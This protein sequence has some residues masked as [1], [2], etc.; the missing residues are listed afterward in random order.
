VGD[1]F[2]SRKKK[3]T[4]RQMRSTSSDAGGFLVVKEDRET[5]MAS[6]TQ[7]KPGRQFRFLKIKRRG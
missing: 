3:A 2:H 1:D 7:I 4:E 6:V 5:L